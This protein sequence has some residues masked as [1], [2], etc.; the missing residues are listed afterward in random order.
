M[1]LH[2]NYSLGALHASKIM[3]SVGLTLVSI[4][5]AAI[6]V[7]C[8]VAPTVYGFKVWRGE[9]LAILIALAAYSTP[10]ALMAGLPVA[11]ALPRIL[12]PFIGLVVG[13][14]NWMLLSW[15]DYYFTGPGISVPWMLI[16][17]IHGFAAGIFAC[18]FQ[19]VARL[20]RF[21]RT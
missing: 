14:A 19:V 7:G 6:I 12:W 2:E 9:A 17:G 13:M 21:D 11:Y 16:G 1:P 10:A 8:F 5:L 18:L 15:L 3:K 20:V 4:A